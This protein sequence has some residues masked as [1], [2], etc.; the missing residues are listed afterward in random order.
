MHGRGTQ[1]QV[2]EARVIEA[3]VVKAR[4]LEALRAGLSTLLIG[5]LCAAALVAPKLTTQPD[6]AHSHPAGTHAHLHALELILGS[7]VPAL[8][9]P[10]A[11][12]VRP[13]ATVLMP[14]TPWVGTLPK[15]A[16]QSRAPPRPVSQ[17][18]PQHS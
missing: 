2:I 18:K 12:Q 16:H 6:F 3:R 8:F 10:A 15:N 5:L 4:V 13:K 7:T 9:I 14:T 17:T 1:P 11:P